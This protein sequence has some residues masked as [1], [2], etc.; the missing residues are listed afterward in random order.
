ML[1]RYFTCPPS[2]RINNGIITYIRECIQ[3]C[4][5]IVALFTV[6]QL[7]DC[8]LLV[9]ALSYFQSDVLSQSPQKAIRTI[10]WW[11]CKGD[12]GTGN[13]CLNLFKLVQT[14]KE[15]RQFQV[16]LNGSKLLILL[17]SLHLIDILL[18]RVILYLTTKAV[19]SVRV[20]LWLDYPDKYTQIYLYLFPQ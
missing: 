14:W 7:S 2:P 3:K 19:I 18:W 20:C 9:C 17:S 11:G 13:V 8:C 12:S 16:L 10:S 4:M 6:V 1:A 15:L 5:C